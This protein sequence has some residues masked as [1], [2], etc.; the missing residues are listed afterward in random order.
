MNGTSASQTFERI[1]MPPKSTM[2]TEMTMARPTAQSGTP[3]KLET[4]TSTMEPDCTAEPMPNAAM[5]ANTA[6]ATAPSFA[7]PGVLP[8]LR[9]KARS[10]AY[11][12]PPSISPLW[13]LT[14]YLTDAKTSEYFVAMPNTPVSHTQSTA[15]GPPERMAVATPTMLPVPM[16]AASAV[17]S[18]PNWLISP[19]ASLSFCKDILMA[20]GSLRWMTRVRNVRKMCEP[21]SR[22]IMGGPQTAPSMALMMPTMSMHGPLSRHAARPNARQNRACGASGNEDPKDRTHQELVKSMREALFPNRQLRPAK[23]PQVVIRG[24]SA[25]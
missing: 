10:H 13:S 8:S 4:T 6:N 21:N 12:A 9:L 7:Q 18:A 15:P 17:V 11:M 24:N 25:H 14:R 16:V 2:A 3:G 22:I 20:V 5:D 19:S 1:W 23:R